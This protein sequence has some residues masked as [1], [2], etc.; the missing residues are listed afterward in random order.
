M[1]MTEFSADSGT[2]LADEPTAAA[3]QFAT[4]DLHLVVPSLTNP[5][6]TFDEAKLGE[7]AESIRASGVHQPVLVR[8]LPIERVDE[9]SRK[10]P[11]KRDARP[12]WEIVAGERRYRASKL[13]GLTT[14]PALIRTLT[15]AQVLEI[16]IVENLQREDLSELEEAE[17]YHRLVEATSIAKEDIGAKIGKSRSYVYQRLKL[18]DLNSAG[19]EALRAGQI[20]A[21]KALLIARVP[22]D[23][24]QIKALGQA[25]GTDNYGRALSV[26]DL[27]TWLQTNVMLALPR[28]RFDIKDVTLR[29]EAGACPAC[30]KRTGAN[31]DL[32]ADVDSM[33][34]CTDPTCFHDKEKTH[35][36]RR[37]EQAQ[38]E[39]KK[40]IDADKAAKLLETGSRQWLKGHQ[41][42]DEYPDHTLGLDSTTLR[43]G[44]GK[45]CPPPVL[46]IHPTTG[47]MAEV[48]PTDQVKKAIKEHSLSRDAKRQAKT[49]TAQQAV[50]IEERMDYARRWQADV[51]ARTD[52]WIKAT[53][54]ALS[55]ELIRAWLFD[56]LASGSDE[57]MGAT[58][59]LPEHFEDA[60]ARNRIAS[61][62]DSGMVLLLTRFML[63]DSQ[64]KWDA[65]DDENVQ[66]QAP[67]TTLF[68][69]IN[70]AGIDLAAARADTK[71][72]IESEERAAKLEEEA[73]APA[74]AP[75]K[76]KKP[77]KSTAS[78]AA[79][80]LRA[81]KPSGDEVQAQ[82]AR[83][84]QALDQAP[85]GAELDKAAALAAAVRTFEI[86][87]IATVRACSKGGDAKLRKAIG[88]VGRVTAVGDDG[89]VALRH[90]EGP[91]DLVMAAHADLDLYTCSP[92]VGSK[93]RV[94]GGSTFD[95]RDKHLWRHGIV[96]A[97]GP[98]GWQVLLTGKNG[99][100][101]DVEL[102]ETNELEVL[103]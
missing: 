87:E 23:K 12:A 42:L 40:V 97:V 14:I 54:P 84:F 4:L 75:E 29:P 80:S 18:L 32:F 19:R 50:P 2:T 17:G 77:K 86:G 72:A 30:P 34:L 93:V 47:A 53:E 85:D 101:A 25:T 38:R 37:F 68:E 74:P 11:G 10:Q 70:M 55:P 95:D 8:R 6:A 36:D 103:E 79:Q 52:T 31:P 92:Q 58:L 27:Q 41:L 102:F 5:R 56:R 81:R 44:L 15:D 89:R 57:A 69:L 9:T 63:H 3:D 76:A 48:L 90:G 46:A 28:A 33:D 16:Q 66:R 1:P 45:H 99:A 61:M 43:K 64:S 21:S 51:L 71:R 7:L 20:D 100:T 94:V 73:K 96:K 22:D 62:S 98:D 67:R 26:K 60:A 39:G 82:I 78:P 24:Q 59:D 13:A 83:E 88:K 65:W 35:D 91:R 49:K